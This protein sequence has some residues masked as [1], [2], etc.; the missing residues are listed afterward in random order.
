M[1]SQSVR[2]KCKLNHDLWCKMSRVRNDVCV[3]TFVSALSELRAAAR[4]DVQGDRRLEVGLVLLLHI[5]RHILK[6]YSQ[7]KRINKYIRKRGKFKLSPTPLTD[8]LGA[9]M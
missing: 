8:P 3:L 1:K 6:L 5:L 9:F 4:S 2:R 7:M